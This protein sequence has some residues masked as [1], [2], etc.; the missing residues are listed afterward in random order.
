M[1]S[2]L[3][4]HLAAC[5]TLAMVGAGLAMAPA[6]GASD[7][8]A[9][10]AGAIG[11]VSCLDTERTYFKGPGSR[12]YPLT[13]YARATSSCGG[14]QVKPKT[15]RYVQVCFR[16]TGCNG[17]K[18]AHADTWTTVATNVAAGTEYRL[19]FRSPARSSGKYVH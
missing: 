19:N 12:H 9:P 14:I 18:L 6:A 2:E 16:E 4:T 1:S 7:S 10:A 13:N 5:A 15:N 8:V 11:A 3:R 17:L